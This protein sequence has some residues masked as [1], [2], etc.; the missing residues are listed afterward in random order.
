MEV[1]TTMFIY[2]IIKENLILDR[3]LKRKASVCNT[4]IQQT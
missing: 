4:A 2:A 3:Y 1:F